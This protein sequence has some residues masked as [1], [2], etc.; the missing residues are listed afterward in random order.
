M[1]LESEYSAFPFEN[2][3]FFENGLTT[4][5]PITGSGERL[6]TLILSRL[7]KP[8]NEEDLILAEYSATVVANGNYA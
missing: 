7:D 6:G 4:I 8:F 2:K 1:S 3:N 5:V